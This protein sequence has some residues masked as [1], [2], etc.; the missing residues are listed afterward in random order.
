MT[1]PSGEIFAKGVEDDCGGVRELIM[2]FAVDV[3]ER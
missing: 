2:T 1:S 3:G